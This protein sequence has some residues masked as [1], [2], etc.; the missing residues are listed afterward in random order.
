MDVALSICLTTWN[1]KYHCWMYRVYIS[2]VLK[3]IALFGKTRNK[4]IPFPAHKPNIPSLRIMERYI[5]VIFCNVEKNPPPI[6]VLVLLVP[7]VRPPMVVEA[8]ATVLYS[9]VCDNILIRSNGLVTVFAI[10]PDIPP[11][12]IRRVTSDPVLDED[13]D[14]CLILLLLMLLLLF[15]VVIRGFLLF[16]LSIEDVV[17]AVMEDMM[18]YVF[19]GCDK[20][21]QLILR[22]MREMV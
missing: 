8:V 5:L 12:I 9:P 3:I 4:L 22:M 11:Q 6:L 1:L 21:Q 20:L 15:D 18:K 10:I 7:R 14:L 17:P 13:D 19:V 16:A 2:L